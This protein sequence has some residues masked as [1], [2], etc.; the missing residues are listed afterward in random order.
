MVAPDFPNSSSVRT[1][2]R[3]NIDVPN[4]EGNGP[5]ERHKND[6]EDDEAV[7]E[8][9]HEVHDVFNRKREIV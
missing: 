4:G 3:G 7:C 5:C 9:G 6:S 8:G 1:R 2:D